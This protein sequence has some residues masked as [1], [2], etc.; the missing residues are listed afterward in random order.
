M[1]VVNMGFRDVLDIIC[2]VGVEQRLKV[3]TA[4]QLLVLMLK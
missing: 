4:R 2:E 1:K 3:G